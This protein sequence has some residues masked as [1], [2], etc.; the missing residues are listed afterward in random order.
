[1][2][3][4]RFSENDLLLQYETAKSMMFREFIPREVP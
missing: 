1:M 4:W 2:K 3:Y